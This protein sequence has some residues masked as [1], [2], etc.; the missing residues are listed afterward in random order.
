MWYNKENYRKTQIGGAYGKQKNRSLFDIDGTIFRDSLMVAHFMKLQDFQIIDDSKWHTQVHLSRSLQKRRLDYD[1]YL[2][3]I[4]SAYEESLKGIS[5]SDVML[6]RAV[7]QNRADEVYKFTR[8]RIEQ[9]RKKR[10]HGHI[11]IQ[12]A[13]TFS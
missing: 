11:H 8:S 1:T 6:Q 7:I 13:P 12:E 10:P 3:S 5:Y 9:H 4:S 2:E